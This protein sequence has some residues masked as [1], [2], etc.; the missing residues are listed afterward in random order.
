[1]K[2]ICLT[3]DSYVHLM[4]GFAD[5]FNKHWGDP[6]T[7]LGYKPPIEKLPDNFE[8]V[9][10]GE[11]P[12]DHDFTTGLIPYFKEL[13]DD[14]FCLFLDD[15]YVTKVDKERLGIAESAVTL[16]LILSCFHPI[17]KFDLSYDRMNFPHTEFD[18]GVILCAQDARYRT[19][20]QAAIWRTSYF[21]RFLVPHRTPW[22]FEL[23]GEK[24][25]MNDDAIILGFTTPVVEYRNV[26]KKGLPL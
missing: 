8:F 25:A 15:Y 14:Y 1:M 23:L 9:S 13:K 24:K 18:N 5:C 19:S 10:L 7:V 22:E 12:P 4:K 17:E 21:R 26:M 11:Q 20:L 6:V 3:S 2:I 16:P